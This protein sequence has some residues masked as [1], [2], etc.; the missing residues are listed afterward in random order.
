MKWWKQQ[1]EI[2][3]STEQQRV[4]KLAQIGSTLRLKRQE[5]KLSLDQVAA[6]TRIRL[7]YLEAIEAGDL[8]ELPEPIY[9]Q[10]FIKQYAEVLGLNGTE[11]ANSFPAT[12]RLPNLKPVGLSLPAAQLQSTH[13]YVLYILVIVATVGALSQTLQRSELQVS[14]RQM[15]AQQLASPVQPKTTAS[16]SAQKVK[17]V[18]ATPSPASKTSKPVQIGVTVK[19]ESWVRVIADGKKQFEGLLPQG[20]QRTWAANQQLIVRVGNAGGVLITFKEEEAKPLGQLGEVQEVTFGADR[21][22]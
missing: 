20:T 4:E 10:G 2:V 15:P 22:L 13:L 7:P 18:S 14:Q 9:I 16:Q 8:D 5:K 19:A 3:Q 12:D 11:L 6:E 21:Q 1:Q 17:P